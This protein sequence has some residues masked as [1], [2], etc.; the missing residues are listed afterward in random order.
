[1][2]MMGG[3]GKLAQ[4]ARN[5]AKEHPDQVRKAVGQAENVLD[6]RTGRKHSHQIDSMGDKVEDFLTPDPSK[7][8]PTAR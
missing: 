6:K 1:M 3:I 4:R 2:G 7:D 8:N 5:L